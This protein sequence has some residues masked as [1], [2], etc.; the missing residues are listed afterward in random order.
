MVEREGKETSQKPRWTL[1]RWR[2]RALESWSA[3]ELQRWRAAALGSAEAS[4][5]ASD[6]STRLS[7]G[8]THEFD[9]ERQGLGPADPGEV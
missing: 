6:S 2:A 7:T 1:E 4:A 9:E 3:G 8:I 5:A